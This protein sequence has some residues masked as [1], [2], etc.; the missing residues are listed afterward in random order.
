MN[1][2]R[3]FFRNEVELL[4]KSGSDVTAIDNKGWNALM[5]TAASIYRR[6]E[7]GAHG[8]G[9]IRW[10]AAVSLIDL[11]IDKGTNVNAVNKQ[12]ETALI[13]AVK[14]GNTHFAHQL[15]S[16][17]ADPYI[18]TKYGARAK[19]FVGKIPR[20]QR[21]ELLKALENHK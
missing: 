5:H 7:V 20:F 21:E 13:L 11:L 10:L 19:D 14:A 2:A 3:R 12:G 15:L 9:Y 16:R 1:S 18:K 8:N 17:G 4:I 6:N